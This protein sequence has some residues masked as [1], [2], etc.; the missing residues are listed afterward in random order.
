VFEV[1]HPDTQ[2]VKIRR[3]ESNWRAAQQPSLRRC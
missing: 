2:R 1:D 3:A